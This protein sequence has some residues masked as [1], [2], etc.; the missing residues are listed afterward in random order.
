MTRGLSLQLQL[1]QNGRSLSSARVTELSEAAENPLGSPQLRVGISPT[2]PHLWWSD[3]SLRRTRKQ[4]VDP[5][6]SW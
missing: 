5:A 1:C 3:G 6:K 2:E 4:R